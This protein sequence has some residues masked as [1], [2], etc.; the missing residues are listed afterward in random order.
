MGVQLQ[1][2]IDDLLGGL[3]GDGL[4][5]LRA[6]G[7]RRIAHAL[8]FLQ[9]MT[10]GLALIFV[11]RHLDHPFEFSMLPGAQSPGHVIISSGAGRALRIVRDA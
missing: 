6:V 11:N 10:A 2:A 9:F 4:A 5:A 8:D 1:D 7:Q 3:G